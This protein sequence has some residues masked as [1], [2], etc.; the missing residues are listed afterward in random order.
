MPI[1]YGI[2]GEGPQEIIPPGEWEEEVKAAAADEL[3]WDGE[4]I[5]ARLYVELPFWLLMDEAQFSISFMGATVRAWLHHNFS[6]LSELRFLDSG[7]NLHYLGP[8]DELTKTPP[9]KKMKYPV[10]R[11]QRSTIGFEV[12]IL[13]EALSVTN[14]V[15]PDDTADNSIKR[16]Y[17]RRQNR[18]HQYFRSLAAAHIPFLNRLIASYRCVSRDPFAYEVSEWDVP[19]WWV[20][21]GVELIRCGLLPYKD[22]DAYPSL[23]SFPTGERTSVIVASHDAI[24]KQ[25]G[26]PIPPGKMELLDAKSLLFRGSFGD[27]VRSA[28]TAIEV[29]VEHQLRR[30]YA[31]R[32]FTDEESTR[33]LEDTKASFHERIAEYEQLSQRRLPGPMVHGLPHLNGL[34]LRDELEWVRWLRHR[35]VHEG[36]RV[37]FFS[38]GMTTRAIETM[39]WLFNWMSQSDPYTPKDSASDEFY[40]MSIGMPHLPCE[41]TAAGVVVRSYREDP[42]VQVIHEDVAQQYYNTLEPEKADDHSESRTNDIELFVAMTA[43]AYRVALK[44]G[45][46]E[47][48]DDPLPRERFRAKVGKRK[49]LLFCFEFDGLPDLKTIGGAIGR[50][51]RHNVEADDRWYGLCVIHHQRG[52]P[53][54]SREL[55]EAIPPEVCELA[56]TNG[57]TLV[58]AL[59]L[60]LLVNSKRSCSWKNADV[61]RGLTQFGRQGNTPPG[62]KRVG[63]VNRLYEKSQALSLDIDAGESIN[64]GDVI[65]IRLVDRYYEQSISSVQLQRQATETATGPCRVGIGT[66]LSKVEVAEGQRVFVRRLAEKRP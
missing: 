24:Q 39:T 10:H 49:T 31:Q 61:L 1:A 5:D 41:Y 4:L 9:P 27:A 6:S 28:V 37:D 64:L 18:T 3:K 54:R 8:L 7:A 25:L 32:G 66:A 53:S 60:R 58:T 44:N 22:Q 30:L 15:P 12:K 45:P 42:N 20:K 63:I 23:I 11:S 26:E 51:K 43:H 35:I 52:I 56:V 48:P 47:A 14:A 57:V 34:R 40:N 36:H 46:P 29:A 33:R 17:T 2:M 13:K 38:R 59:D 62:Y 55:D 65:C 16:S 50:L 21:N 19:I